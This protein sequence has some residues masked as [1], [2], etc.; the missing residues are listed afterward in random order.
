MPMTHKTFTV[1]ER[2]WDRWAAIAREL[3]ISTSELIRRSVAK[4]TQSSDSKASPEI[5]EGLQCVTDALDTL[6]A[7]AQALHTDATTMPSVIEE[8]TA[9]YEK[10]LSPIGALISQ[11]NRNGPPTEKEIEEMVPRYAGH[12]D[13]DFQ[14]ARHALRNLA[15]RA[16]GAEGG[17]L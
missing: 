4:Y 8:D 5:I 1:E 9:E 7:Q 13:G 16:R 11:W 2:E 12:Y 6:L 14:I 10:D 3:R 15:E 17:R